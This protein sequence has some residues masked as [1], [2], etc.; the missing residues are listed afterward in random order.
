MTVYGRYLK[1]GFQR[2][3]IKK[4]VNSANMHGFT[5]VELIIVIVLIGILTTIAVPSMREWARQGE[6]QS[7]A[8][9][10]RNLFELVRTN[11]MSK[12]HVGYVFGTSKTNI[13]LDNKA[14]ALNGQES[15]NNNAAAI[16]AF[17]DINRD[18]EYTPGVDEIVAIVDMGRVQS[19]LNGVFAVLPNGISGR[20]NGAGPKWYTQLDAGTD[21]D[22]NDHYS[23]NV[24]ISTGGKDTFNYEFTVSRSGQF[25]EH[26]TRSGTNNCQAN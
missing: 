6:V 10:V 13:G 12:G 25:T 20:L 19:R 21:T 14:V 1:K 18:Q 2:G 15:V 26:R 9:E 23:F 24:C 5:L 3:S 4:Q 17:V 7:K 16:V 22:G 11:A 8:E